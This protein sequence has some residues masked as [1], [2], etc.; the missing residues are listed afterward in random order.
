MMGSTLIS[1]VSTF[2]LVENRLNVHTIYIFN[3]HSC[4]FLL[5]YSLLLLLIC[6]YFWCSR[7]LRC[8]YVCVCCDHRLPILIHFGW[9]WRA[10]RIIIFCN[11][12]EQWVK[13]KKYY[14][15]KP[16]KKEANNLGILCIWCG[17]LNQ[18]CK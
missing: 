1:D 12:I 14:I 17:S 10:Q 7:A 15:Y 16:T 5:S 9:W 2:Q 13:L 4:F 6:C 8:F 18:T 11:V 3:S